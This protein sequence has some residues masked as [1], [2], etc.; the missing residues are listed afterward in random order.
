MPRAV[1]RKGGKQTI[2]FSEAGGG[3]TAAAS[4]PT[5]NDI[6]RW[7]AA[8]AAFAARASRLFGAKNTNTAKI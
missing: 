7:L 4:H 6:W 1:P 2:C 5:K 8:A 3:Q